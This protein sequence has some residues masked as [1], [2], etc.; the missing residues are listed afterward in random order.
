MI[1][2]WETVCEE[3]L[4][5]Q[6]AGVIDTNS[7]SEALGLAAD[8]TKG[9][10]PEQPKQLEQPEKPVEPSSREPISSTSGGGGDKDKDE[11]EDRQ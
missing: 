7:K 8:A 5:N 3:V 10:Q 6:G 2:V 4:K 9:E 1:T 11:D